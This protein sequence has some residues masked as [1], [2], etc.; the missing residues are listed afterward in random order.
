MIIRENRTYD[1]MLGD[2]AT[3]VMSSVPM[4]SNRS[5]PMAAVLEQSQTTIFTRGK[6]HIPDSEDPD[7]VRHYKLVRGHWDYGPVPRG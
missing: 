5:A 4:S 1:Q 7:I 3:L 6:Y 2:V